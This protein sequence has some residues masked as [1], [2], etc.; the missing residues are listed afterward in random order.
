MVMLN[1]RLYEGKTLNEI[2]EQGRKRLPFW[3]EREK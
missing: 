3:W 2:G 1:G